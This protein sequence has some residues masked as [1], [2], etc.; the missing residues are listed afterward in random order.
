MTAL[1]TIGKRLSRA[2]ALDLG[3]SSITWCNLSTDEVVEE[4]NFALIDEKKGRV[5]EIGESAA[6]AQGRVQ[7]NLRVVRPFRNGRLVDLEIAERFFR[8]LFAKMGF[9]RFSKPIVG[10][11]TPPFFT[12]AE[13]RVLASTMSRAGAS[14]VVFID[15]IVA[16]AVGA[17]LD[18]QGPTGVMVASFGAQTTF[19][20][21]LSLGESLTS[22]WELVGGDTISGAIATHLRSQYNLVMADPDVEELKL[23]LLDLSTTSFDLSAKVVGRNVESGD[24]QE[25]T[26]SS[27]EV[28]DASSDTVKLMVDTVI[29]TL[30]SAPAEISNDLSRAG[31][32]LI[33]RTS[34]TR[35]ID[36]L[37]AQLTSLPVV[38]SDIVERALVLGTARILGQVSTS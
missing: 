21:I 22:N 3:S 5:V 29:A 33:G 14:R 25:E 37:L 35:G 9:G 2:V 34:L 12:A 10:I 20:G 1:L 30:T 18:I 11:S 17:M 28:F 32:V 38:R 19:S 7:G 26:V 27:A 24:E 8:T 6:S 4:S 23:S 36:D 31:I 16:G 13:K 15:A